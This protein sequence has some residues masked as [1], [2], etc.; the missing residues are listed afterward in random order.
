MFRKSLRI[1]LNREWPIR[2][3]C[4]TIR[5]PI[6]AYHFLSDPDLQHAETKYFWDI[7]YTLSYLKKNRVIAAAGGTLKFFQTYFSWNNFLTDTGK[8]YVGKISLVIQRKKNPYQA[9]WS[10][11]SAHA[12]YTYGIRLMSSSLAQP[13]GAKNSIACCNNY[14][15]IYLAQELQ[16]V[17]Q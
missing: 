12:I 9:K 3:R 14:Y 15:A 10:S 6:P 11:R 13:A 17:V 1:F 2:E 7:K 16:N 5:I 4:Y 8:F